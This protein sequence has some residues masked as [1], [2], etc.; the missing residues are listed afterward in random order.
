MEK[1]YKPIYYGKEKNWN[2][3]VWQYL[4]DHATITRKGIIVNF[5]IRNRNDWEYRIGKRSEGVQRVDLDI[6]ERDINEAG[7]NQ[8]DL[9]IKYESLRGNI[10]RERMIRKRWRKSKNP[11][12]RLIRWL[13]VWTEQIMFYR[14]KDLQ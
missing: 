13:N 3:A 12:K 11:I 6:I 9:N 2:D 7:F 1:K 14:N 4:M 8:L 10:K 5:M